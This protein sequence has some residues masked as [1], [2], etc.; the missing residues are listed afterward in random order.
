[1]VAHA[2]EQFTNR[3]DVSEVVRQTG[4]SH[5]RFIELFRRAVGLTP[6]LYCRVHRFQ[7]VVER[8]AARSSSES[9]VELAVAAGYSDSLQGQFRSRQEIAGSTLIPSF[10]QY[11]TGSG[12]DRVLPLNERGEVYFNRLSLGS[13]RYRSRFCIEWRSSF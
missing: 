6:K 2:L 8:I 5:R 11:R 10:T 4:Y 3:D 1:A 12:S 7:R 9:W 13:G